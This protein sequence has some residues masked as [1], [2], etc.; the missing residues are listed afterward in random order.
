MGKKSSKRSV[1][2]FDLEAALEAAESQEPDSAALAAAGI[3]AAEEFEDSEVRSLV[4]AKRDIQA[5]LGIEE[6][7]QAPEAT[8]EAQALAVETGK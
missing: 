8:A 4:E 3:E 6:F 2:Q 7:W 1:N 5:R